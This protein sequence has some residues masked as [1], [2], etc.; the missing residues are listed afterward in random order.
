MSKSKDKLS[1]TK[2]VIQDSFQ[3]DFEEIKRGSRSE[4]SSVAKDY[5]KAIVD[6]RSAPK[7]GV[8]T[9]IGGFPGRTGVERYTQQLEVS[10]GTNGFGYVTVN[11]S[12]VDISLGLDAAGPF[13]DRTQIEYTMASY[14][15]TAI[16]QEAASVAAGVQQAGWAQSKH[17][18]TTSTQ[19][20]L[21]WRV[22]G[23]TMKVFPDSSF[24]DQNG[25]IILLEPPS[26]LPV[27]RSSSFTSSSLESA[28]TSRVVRATQ[29]GSQ[30]E[31]IV[32][33]WHPKGSRGYESTGHD[34]FAFY[35]TYPNTNQPAKVLGAKDLIMGFVCEAGTQ[36]HV[37]ITAMYELKGTYIT[38]LKPRLVDSRGM[39]LI[40]NVF[41]SKM[42]AGYVGVPEQIYESYMYKIWEGAKKFGG[43][44]S[45]HESEIVSGIGTGLKAI[46]GFM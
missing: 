24:M 15:G 42:V 29:T 8:P 12:D 30:K 33:N 28:P 38:N 41:S 16:H 14:A 27:N 34:D 44:L 23:C 40:Q 5:L 25:R 10:T 13:N 22:V 20:G 9:N 21:Q 4:L 35:S 7:V 45:K 26:H 32:I 39:D 46:G 6:T 18:C 17:F 2:K 1:R 3:K 31:A 43:F 37:E 11:L 36:F 19:S